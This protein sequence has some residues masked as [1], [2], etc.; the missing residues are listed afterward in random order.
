MHPKKVYIEV[1]L[2]IF[3]QPEKAAL[4]EMSKGR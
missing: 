1:Y 2:K 3:A 4:K